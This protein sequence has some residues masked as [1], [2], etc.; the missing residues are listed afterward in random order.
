MPIIAAILIT[1]IEGVR[2]VHP[3]EDRAGGPFM[4]CYL[5]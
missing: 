1:L 5:P 2:D 3:L 4:H